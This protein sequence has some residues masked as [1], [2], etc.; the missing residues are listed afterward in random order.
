MRSPGI[1]KT[2]G[3]AVVCA[4]SRCSWLKDCE[5]RKTRITRKKVARKG[6]ADDADF[7]DILRPGF[8]VR[9]GWADILGGLGRVVTKRGTTNTKGKE[10]DPQINADGHRFFDI[11]DRGA[12]GSAQ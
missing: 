5:P 8:V 12:G 1:G 2:E 6:T 9:H 11:G 4:V 10:G 7:T 3:L